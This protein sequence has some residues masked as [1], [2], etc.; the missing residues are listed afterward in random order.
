M[1]YALLNALLYI[2]LL[3]WYKRKYHKID[4]GFLM[5]SLWT[6]IA[7]FCFLYYLTVPNKYHL[8]LW[9]FLYLFFAFILYIRI[10][11]KK[12]R[13][14]LNVTDYTPKQNKIIDYI[15]YF[16]VFCM[17]VNLL[18]ADYNLASFSLSNV[19]ENAADSYADFHAAEAWHSQT[20]LERIS[21]NYAVWFLNVAIIGAF[22]WIVRGKE[23]IGML[24]LALIVIDQGLKSIQIASRGSLFVFVLLLLA[25]YLIY[26]DYIPHKTKKTL[27]QA[28]LVSGGVLLIYM[29]AI[30]ISRFGEMGEGGSDSLF[31]YFGHSMLT[32]NYGVADSM[33][34]TFMGA[35]TFRNFIGLDPEFVFDADLML[36]THFNTG[37]ITTI[38]MLC[39]DF[40]FIGTIALGLVLPWVLLRL[41]KLDNSIGGI[42][43]YVF[44]L[45]RMMNGVFVN[46]SGADAAYFS[47][48]LVYLILF[49]SM[50]LVGK[51]KKKS[52]PN[53]VTYNEA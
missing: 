6:V 32:F 15:C 26:K 41:I 44:Y 28:A 10:F 13:E 24:L 23:K 8:Q 3:I 7:V 5:I 12:E 37:F 33:N 53:I 30:T 52:K 16:Y 38:G 42:F 14:V 2:G 35:R 46:G 50:K 47:M 1:I 27:F 51:K 4:C 9:P 21:R 25:V 29:L 45:H 43:V 40:G 49:V 22:H 20:L 18:S 31:V 34:G 17:F 39:L 11:I 19:Q 36:G 48:V